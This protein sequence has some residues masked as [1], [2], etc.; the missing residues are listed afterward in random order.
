MRFQF[1][2]AKKVFIITLIIGIVLL[3]GIFGSCVVHTHLKDDSKVET[4][5]NV[6]RK[7]EKVSNSTYNSTANFATDYEHNTEPTTEQIYEYTVVR[8]IDGDTLEVEIEE[9]NIEKLRLIGI[10]TPES[11]AYDDSKNCSYG[12]IA[13]A[14]TTNL[15]AGKKIIV[16]YD[17]EPR[18]DYRRLL[19]YVYINGEMINKKLILEGYAVAKQFPP[20]TKYAELFKSAQIEAEKNKSGMWDDEITEQECNLKTEYYIEY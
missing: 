5:E 17:E 7:S 18:D 20:N 9:G 10:D 15:L 14:Y 19:G 12:K 2:S 8:V 6:I 13:A 11:V 4:T 3:L 16:E 1:V